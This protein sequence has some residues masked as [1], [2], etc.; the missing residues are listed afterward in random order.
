MSQISLTEKRKNV[1]WGVFLFPYLIS[2]P[3]DTMISDEGY[4]HEQSTIINE[5]VHISV[6]IQTIRG[7]TP[8]TM[9]PSHF[10]SR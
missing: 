4:T 8:D 3:P 1:L 2:P 6:Y 5:G 7:V 10:Q 9:D